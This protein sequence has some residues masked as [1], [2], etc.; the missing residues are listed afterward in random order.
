MESVFINDCEY[1]AFTNEECD[2]AALALHLAGIDS[3]PVW[4][5]EGPDAVVTGRILHASDLGTGLEFGSKSLGD[6]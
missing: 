4:A 3:A 2:R 1:P 5:G 6:V